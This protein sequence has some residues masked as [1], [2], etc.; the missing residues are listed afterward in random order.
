MLDAANVPNDDGW[1]PLHACCHSHSTVAAGLRLVD[2]IA[3]AGGS[4]DL[5]TARG[6]GAYNAGW[7]PLH[8]AAAYGVVESRSSRGAALVAD[9]AE[10][11]S[12]PLP[13]PSSARKVRRRAARRGARR[14]GRGRAADQQPHVDAA[15][16]GVPPRLPLDRQAA[17]RRAARR[18]PRVRARRRGRA[19]VPVRAAA[20]AVRAR[21]G[22]PLRLQR[23]GEAAAR[24]RRAEGRAEPARL[25]RAARG[26]VPQPRRGERA[27]ARETVPSLAPRTPGT[28]AL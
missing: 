13:I 11:L 15:A 21:R 27:R 9:E 10:A 4:L 20:A 26:G 7:T 22:V 3:R 24:A 23:D 16:R 19:R 2:E 8:M 17:A 5:K 12:P 18:G 25:D 1:T 6:P 28:F 14:R